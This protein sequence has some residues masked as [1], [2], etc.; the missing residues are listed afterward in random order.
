MGIRNLAT[1]IKPYSKD[2]VLDSSSRIVVDGP[3]LAYHIIS[4]C[5]PRQGATTPFQQPS[6][7]LLAG[8]ALAWLQ[9][10]ERHGPTVAAIY[11]D[12]HLPRRKLAERLER[13][14]K[15][16]RQL[17][18]FFLSTPHGVSEITPCITSVEAVRLFSL[19][20]RLA[21]STP[22]GS[23]TLPI[24]SFAVGTIYDALRYSER[25][26]SLTKLVP[27]EADC[28]C[29]ESVRVAGGIILTSDSDLLVFDLGEDG[30]VTLFQDIGVPAAGKTAGSVGGFHAR[31][32]TPAKIANRL[33]LPK[34]YG[35][36]ALAFEIHMDTHISPGK[37]LEKSR[38]SAAIKANPKEYEVF[39]EQYRLSPQD[40]TTAAMLSIE[41][42]KPMDSRTSEL[43]IQSL[44]PVN[45]SASEV[46]DG[47]GEASNEATMFLPALVDAW[48]RSSAWEMSTSVRELAYSVL[49]LAQDSANKHSQ[50][51]EYRR[52]LSTKPSG[53][54]L[55]LSNCGDIDVSC[56]RLTE[57]IKK[58]RSIM[59]SQDPSL[60]WTV[61]GFH[62]EL[63][64]SQ[65]AGKQ[66]LGLHVL[67]YW[68]NS[69]GTIRDTASW[70]ILHFV[71]QTN[72]LFY[73]LGM[74]RQA[75][76]FVAGRKPLPSPALRGLSDELCHIPHV[77]KYCSVHDVKDLPQRLKSAGGLDA[78]QEIADLSKPIAFDDRPKLQGKSKKKRKRTADASGARA[79]PKMAGKGRNMFSILDSMG[80]D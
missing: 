46:G 23:G 62:E 29:A 7:D 18:N 80:S 11:F 64:C 76:D 33:G 15:V 65:E 56:T 9:E 77:T 3:S 57:I 39:M 71:A 34:A 45:V 27:E 4:L 10:L 20:G 41:E 49:Q 28:Y 48:S 40:I 74:L 36:S 6:Y 43:V 70:D 13:S 44:S 2:C 31:T 53:T 54:L 66:P 30:S 75:L 68:T 50:V 63:R 55:E 72:G 21:T 1:N 35:L 38:Q 67:T 5:S 17:N 79:S 58:I 14:T 24:P 52:L 47:T 12:G 73:S 42:M 37:L 22:S 32:Y 25:Y 69:D 19:D 78:L 60:A 51:R 26:G 61:F 59:T 16:S 8:T